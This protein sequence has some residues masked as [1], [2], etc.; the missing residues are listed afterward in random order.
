[1]LF[2]EVNKT[3]ALAHFIAARTMQPG[4]EKNPVEYFQRQIK[5]LRE[6][7]VRE[8]KMDQAS[9]E[10]GKLWRSCHNSPSE[11]FRW[12][13]GVLVMQ[14][15]YLCALIANE[16]VSITPTADVESFKHLLVAQTRQNLGQ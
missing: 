13:E 9:E 6:R 10:F 16:P 1:M 5:E 12:L 14:M 2:Y 8:R 4:I 11:Y 15:S 3:D 7:L